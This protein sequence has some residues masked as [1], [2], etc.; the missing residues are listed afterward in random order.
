M[1][2]TCSATARGRWPGSSTPSG[3]TLE[4]LRTALLERDPG[5][6]RGRS[7]RSELLAAGRGRQDRRRRPE[8]PRARRRGGGRAPTAPLLFAKFPSSRRGRWRRR[9]LVRRVTA[10][11][12]YEAELAV[13]IG[14]RAR[15]VPVTTRSTTSSATPASTTSRP[16]TSRC[17]D[18]QWTRAKSLDTFC[19]MGPWIVTADE[20]PDPR[21][22]PGALPRQRRVAPGRHDG[23]ARP[24]RRG[25]D[26]LLLAVV[27]AGAGR[28]HRDWD[29]RRGRGLPRPAGVPRGRRRRSRSRSS[30]SAR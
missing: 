8:L 3:T 23:R 16:A 20:I 27:H 18:G 28:R 30:A 10:Q 15:D 9:S 1:S 4:A 14:R 21:R 24:R 17:S 29:A 12:D 2:R 5:A 13:V 22:A 25:A 19:P 7:R 26:R 6:R 11:V